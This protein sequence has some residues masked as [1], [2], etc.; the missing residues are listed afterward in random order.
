[1]LE[2]SEGD[3][4]KLLTK[5]IEN[6]LPKLYSQEDKGM[7]AIAQVKFFSLGSDWRWF[8]TEFDGED[9]F[10]GLVQGF[11]NELG[12]FSLSELQSVKFMGIPAI[13]RDINWKPKPLKE[14]KQQ[15]EEKGFA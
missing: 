11:E 8:A 3:R 14:I 10:F 2:L 15:L 7:E 5:E 13:E 12:Y 4:M 6:K 9:T 1:M